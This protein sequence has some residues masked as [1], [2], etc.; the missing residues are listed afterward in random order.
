[1]STSV[2][3]RVAELAYEAE[4]RNA[5]VLGHDGLDV[6]MLSFGAFCDTLLLAYSNDRPVVEPRFRR[7][8]R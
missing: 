1:M 6:A 3:I 7:L 2:A 8:M 5:K 4:K